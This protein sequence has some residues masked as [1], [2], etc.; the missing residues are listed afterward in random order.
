MDT[1]TTLFLSSLPFSICSPIPPLPSHLHPPHCPHPLTPP[2]LLPYSFP[3]FLPSP[4]LSPPSPRVVRTAVKRYWFWF[5]EK[6]CQLKYYRNQEAYIQCIHEPV[7]C[8]HATDAHTHTHTHTC[9]H[10]TC[11]SAHMHTHTLTYT[12]THT[13]HSHTHTHTH[14]HRSI[15]LRYAKVTPNLTPASNEFYIK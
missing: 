2:L 5:D 7:G 15:D 9:I 3:S 10:T 11:T 13:T 6:S 1:H 4:S 12:Y 8:V 14:T